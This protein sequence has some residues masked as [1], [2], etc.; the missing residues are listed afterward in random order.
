MSLNCL[1][2]ILQSEFASGCQ[3]FGGG[4]AFAGQDLI[5]NGF[6]RTNG[7]SASNEPV[8]S[9]LFANAPATTGEVSTPCLLFDPEHC[10]C[11]A[12]GC[13]H[14]FHMCCI[15]A[16]QLQMVSRLCGCTD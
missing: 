3:K 10:M 1:L 6:A 9:S 2:S 8:S 7:S 14:M 12:Q 11:A 15:C 16:W 13:G 5:S 4:Q